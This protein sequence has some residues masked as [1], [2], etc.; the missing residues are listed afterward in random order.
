M[1]VICSVKLIPNCNVTIQKIMIK[2]LVFINIS[3][4]VWSQQGVGLA[5]FLILE[6]AHQPS[7]DTN[8]FLSSHKYS[9]LRWQIFLGISDTNLLHPL[10]SIQY[11]TNGFVGIYLTSFHILEFGCYFGR[12]CWLWSML[13][14]FPRGDNVN[15]GVVIV[16]RIGHRDSYFIGKGCE[17]RIAWASNW[18]N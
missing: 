8:I 15:N 16:E 13:V 17:L 14:I 7:S 10:S 6:F 18:S 1:F 5:P 12:H 2:N 9:P 4:I 11:I 3:E